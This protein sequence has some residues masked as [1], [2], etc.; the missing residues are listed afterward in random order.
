[1]IHEEVSGD[2]IHRQERRGLTDAVESLEEA[3][4]P[5][6]HGIRR[7]RDLIYEADGEDRPLEL[8]QID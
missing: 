4:D 7:A 3:R 1:M 8:G 5:Q 6:T 2:S